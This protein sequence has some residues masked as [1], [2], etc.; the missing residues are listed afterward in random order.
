MSMTAVK[1]ERELLRKDPR[2]E[3]TMGSLIAAPKLPRVMIRET[4]KVI[5]MARKFNREV[6][7]PRALELDLQKMEDPDYLPWDLVEEAN[8]RGFFTLF[9]PKIFGGQGINLPAMSYFCEEL[10]S[11]CLG[12][13]NVVA[14]HYL[15]VSTLVST[16]NI[17]LMNR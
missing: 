14:V 17:R 6:V 8:R 10:A 13:A 16:W 15:G 7:E 11:V 2:P 3:V 9:E 12:I 5:A 4:K 1:S